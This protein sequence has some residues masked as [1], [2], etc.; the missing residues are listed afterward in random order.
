VLP[1]PDL[2]EEFQMLT[3]N[4]SAQYGNVAGAINNL[5]TKSGTNDFHG[6]VYWFFRNDKLDANEFFR[7][8]NAAGDPALS[9]ASLVRFN[10]FGASGTGRIIK[11]KLFY[12]A[13]YEGSRFNT[14]AAAVPIVVETAE[15]RQAVAAANPNSVA[16]L[17]YNNFAPSTP[18]TPFQTLAEYVTGGA[19]GFG[20]S[21]FAEYLCP[22]TSGDGR[23]ALGIGPLAGLQ[24]MFGIEAGDI[25]TGLLDGTGL[26]DYTMGAGP[27]GIAGTADDVIVPN[28]PTYF[29]AP[30]SIANAPGLL[31]GSI[32]RNIP[33]FNTSVAVF[34]TQSQ[35]FGDLAH[36]D[37]ASARFDWVGTRAA[38]AASATRR[39][40]RPPTSPEAGSGPSPRRSSTTS[41]SA[42][43]ATRTS[44]M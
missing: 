2:V 13:S 23:V 9:E 3:L 26:T 35:T 36:G 44:S 10:Q 33:L 8:L 29:D 40:S 4:N 15:W 32:S 28:C 25:G 11:D 6:S 41:A 20:A 1:N 12:T 30:G 21:T 39:S 38:P 18:G 24:S 34:G 19:G 5:V 27:D 31:A 43:P 16:A 14:A 22:D 42:S 7:N 37:R 17:L